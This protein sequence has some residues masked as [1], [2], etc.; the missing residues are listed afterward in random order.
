[1]THSK[2]VGEYGDKKMVHEVISNPEK[3]KSHDRHENTEEQE[4]PWQV[5]YKSERTDRP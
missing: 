4:Q 5:R 2:R 3:S 1:M